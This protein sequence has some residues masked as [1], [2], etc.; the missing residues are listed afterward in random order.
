M[1]RISPWHAGIVTA[2]LVIASLTT[3]FAVHGAPATCR[4]NQLGVRPNGSEGTA[5]TIHGAWVFTNLSDASC[6]LNGYASLQ[7]YGKAGRPIHTSVQDDLSPSPSDVTLAPGASATFLS[8]Y[9]D[10]S[11]GKPCPTSFVAEITAPGTVASQFIPASLA[12]CDGV[13][14]VSAVRA[15]VHHP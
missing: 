8:N 4:R 12:P 15:G 10:V 5:G 1:R 2:V 13:V 11:S 14:H 9:S 7:L 6:L 3:A